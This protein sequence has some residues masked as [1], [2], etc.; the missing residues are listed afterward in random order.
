MGD[1]GRSNGEPGLAPDS[2]GAHSRW[3]RK[4]QPTAAQGG[5]AGQDPHPALTDLYQA[6][7]HSL[8]RLAALLVGDTTTAEAVVVD[9]FVAFHRT[10]KTARTCADALPPLRRLVVARSR[11]AA[12]HHPPDTDD[13]SPVVA[14][15]PGSPDRRSR[16]PPFE[17]STVVL[18][19][20]AL[21]L[22]QREAVVLM[23][24]LDLTDEQAAAAMRVSQTALRRHLA[25]AKTA[26]RAALPGEP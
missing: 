14:R 3:R 20:A 4:E 25:A 5:G 15:L 6:H 24:Y 12:R 19:L 9:S 26:L 16:I 17:N 2:P 13:W 21:P 11:S 22:V 10:R 7:Y 1:T 23:L 8:L 18:A